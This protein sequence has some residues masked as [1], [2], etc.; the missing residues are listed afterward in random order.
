MD[1]YDILVAKAISGSGG[2]G[3]GGGATLLY[4]E[5]LGTLEITGTS[6]VEVGTITLDLK[7][8]EAGVDRFGNYDLL[9]VDVSSDSEPQIGYHIKTITPC[10]VYGDTNAE[11]RNSAIVPAALNYKLYTDGNVVSRAGVS[12]YGIYVNIISTTSTGITISLQAK[13]SGTHTA[14]INSAYTARVYGLKWADIIA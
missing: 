4:T 6:T 10:I 5:S 12:K 2:G 3:G 9:F 1:L 13:Y 7:D 14:T 11:N 8:T